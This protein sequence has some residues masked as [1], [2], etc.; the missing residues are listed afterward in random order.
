MSDKGKAEFVEAVLHMYVALPE[1]PD[2]FNGHDSLIAARW[3]QEGY[4][5]LQIQQ[6]MTLARVRRR[7][8]R[9]TDPPLNPI[10]SLQ[11]FTPIL[12]ELQRQPMGEKYFRYLQQKLPSGCRSD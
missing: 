1:T 10:H 8:R 5:L 11:Y 4:T 9:S 3:Q 7:F 2:R 12:Q 6:A